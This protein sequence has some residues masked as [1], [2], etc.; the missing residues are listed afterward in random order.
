MGGSVHFQGVF[1]PPVGDFLHFELAPLVTNLAPS[2][3]EVSVTTETLLNG[4]QRIH[5]LLRSWP[6]PNVMP[7]HPNSKDQQIVYNAPVYSDTELR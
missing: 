2:N 4:D 6:D 7:K 1:T 5:I 3:A